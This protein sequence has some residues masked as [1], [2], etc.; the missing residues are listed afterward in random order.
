MEIVKANGPS[1]NIL[2]QV[3]LPASLLA[4]QGLSSEDQGIFFA[5]G[6]MGG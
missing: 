2:V 6:Y 3:A 5:R 1:E 4:E